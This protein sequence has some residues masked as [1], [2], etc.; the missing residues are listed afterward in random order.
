MRC[1]TGSLPKAAIIISILVSCSLHQI[2]RSYIRPRRHN[3]KLGS[4]S[5]VKTTI[6]I[7]VC[8]T[9]CNYVREFSRITNR[10]IRMIPIISSACNKENIIIVYCCV[11]SISHSRRLRPKARTNINNTGTIFCR[12]LYG[13]NCKRGNCR[14]PSIS[15]Y[16]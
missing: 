8:C 12:I 16:H 7:L 10:G 4:I 13:L 5:A 1:S 11:N 3:I 9:D 6:V 15:Q 2:G 14:L